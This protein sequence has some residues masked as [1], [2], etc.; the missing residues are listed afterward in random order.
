M[1]DVS[2]VI[3]ELE[4]SVTSHVDSISGSQSREWHFPDCAKENPRSETRSHVRFP[5]SWNL[6]CRVYWRG[7]NPLELAWNN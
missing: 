2:E 5:C 7:I 3:E 1:V 6:I 4:L